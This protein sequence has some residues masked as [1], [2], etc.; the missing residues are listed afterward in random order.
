MKYEP[1]VVT[2][3]GQR[4]YRVGCDVNVGNKYKKINVLGY[5]AIYDDKHMKI[6]TV[7]APIMMWILEAKHLLMYIDVTR[8][9][10]DWWQANRA[11]IQSAI[12]NRPYV[13]AEPLY[14]K[15]TLDPVGIGFGAI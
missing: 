8:D 9:T 1:I 2:E 3:N 14:K 12:R 10:N 6:G 11:Y 13:N 4:S 5:E 15:N 7:T